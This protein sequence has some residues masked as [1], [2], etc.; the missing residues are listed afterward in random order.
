VVECRF[1]VAGEHPGVKALLMT[2]ADAVRFR[3]GKAHSI[4]ASTGY[5]QEGRFRVAVSELGDY[6][7]VLD[8]RL[9]GRRTA[10][11][12]VKVSLTFSP[13]PAVVA[14]YATPERKAFAIALSVIFFL[15]ISAYAGRK[16]RASFNDRGNPQ[17][18]PP[19]Y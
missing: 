8:N 1:H 9:E 12:R 3:A 13:E 17:Q 18:Q 2:S 15:G 6:E 4:L 5:Q 10:Q 19:F 7:V 14:R 16:I 11:V